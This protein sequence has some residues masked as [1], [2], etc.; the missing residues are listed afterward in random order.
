MGHYPAG[1]AL[2]T[3][4][5]L[6]AELKVGMNT[7]RAAHRQLAQEGLI[8]PRAGV[9]SIVQDINRKCKRGHVLIVIPESK[10]SYFVS[11]TT[12]RLRST[13]SQ[14]G[15]FVDE[16]VV[17]FDDRRMHRLD[18]L[19]YHLLDGVDL[20][21]QFH[22]TPAIRQALVKSGVPFMAMD[23]VHAACIRAANCVCH[24]R[25][26][27]DGGAEALFGRC[28]AAGVKSVF[29]A[30]AWHPS[31]RLSE[32][33]RAA[34]LDVVV[35]QFC[36][37]ALY[38]MQEGTRRA[39]LEATGRIVAEERHLLS[40]LLMFPDDDVFAAGG[41]MALAYAGLRIPEDV[42][43]ATF[44]NRGSGPVYPIV[45]DRLE[46]DFERVADCIA[47]QA[48]AF[49]ERRDVARTVDVA[50]EYVSGESIGYVHRKPDGQ[51]GQ[52]VVDGRERV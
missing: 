1:S 35:R 32:L 41:L 2:P 17:P 48:L 29:L 16:V 9:G 18:L 26:R 47:S 49:L 42:K 7:V 27:L 5:E 33:A 14:G 8:V 38:G 4:H 25:V 6:S 19:E 43:V 46:L 21:I 50:T 11:M 24:V 30:Y 45:L 52:N 13:L 3:L 34:G 36:S 31:S 28:R 22:K 39:G 20:A 15:Y 12:A 40:G 51:N 37:S 44:S 23:F 10:S